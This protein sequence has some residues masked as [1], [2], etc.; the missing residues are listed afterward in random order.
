MMIAVVQIG[1]SLIAAAIVVA[2]MAWAYNRIGEGREAWR[3]RERIAR[4]ER[5][6]LLLL[7][8]LSEARDQLAVERRVFAQQASLASK[9]RS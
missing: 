2:I 1:S 7:D 8:A 5:H 9:K 4:L 6:N 3:K